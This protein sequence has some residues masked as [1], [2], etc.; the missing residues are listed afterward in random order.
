LRL[1]QRR[2]Q[3]MIGRMVMPCI[4]RLPVERHE[5]LKYSVSIMVL[6]HPETPPSDF[7]PFAVVGWK[8][9]STGFQ[10][11]EHSTVTDFGNAGRRAMVALCRRPK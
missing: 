3:G 5:S 11:L 10:S 6:C 4:K 7:G 9:N 1:V 8:K 2:R